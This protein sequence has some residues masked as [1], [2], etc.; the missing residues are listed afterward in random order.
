[1]PPIAEHTAEDPALR[2]KNQYIAGHPNPY[3]G[4]VR[5]Q[6]ALAIQRGDGSPRKGEVDV[7]F[8]RDSW[9]IREKFVGGRLDAQFDKHTEWTAEGERLFV[10]VRSVTDDPDAHDRLLTIVREAIL[11]AGINLDEKDVAL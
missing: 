3:P 10:Q 1:M 8:T 9:R 6:S 2:P 5:L 7:L 11:S 4:Y